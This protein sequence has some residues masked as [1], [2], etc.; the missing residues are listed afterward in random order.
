MWGE[1]SQLND[2]RLIKEIIKQR[3]LLY[4]DM[5]IVVGWDIV[6]GFLMIYHNFNFLSRYEFPEMLSSYMMPNILGMTF[7]LLGVMIIIGKRTESNMMVSL[8]LAGSAFVWTMYGMA[9]LLASPPN[10]VWLYA[11]GAVVLCIKL[12]IRER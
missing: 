2:I 1:G 10:G 3:F 7:I 6:Y 9:F 4:A 8:G 11:L 5:A 12:A